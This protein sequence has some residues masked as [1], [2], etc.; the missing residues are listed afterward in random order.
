MPV[1]NE[2]L[3]NYVRETFS[4]EDE[5]LSTIRTEIPRRG[6][7]EITVRP[8][9]GRFLQ[10]IVAASGARMAVEIG[11]L[12]G[13]SGVWIAR[14]LPPGGKL[15]SLELSEEHAAVAADH[16]EMAG[17]AD[18]VDL[19]VGDAHDLLKDLANEGPFEFVFIDADKEGYPAYLDW[20]EAN[21]RPR[22]IVAGHNAF[23]FGTIDD[24]SDSDPGVAALRL[25]NER[26]A[27]DDHFI[28]TVFPAGDGTAVGVLRKNT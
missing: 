14:G 10:F 24:S 3:E 17:L 1:Y 18:K 13:Y 28:S 12:G 4:A 9:E 8:E 11:T 16:F 21:L 22:G 2:A 15:I 27:N 7:P 23:G 5:I 25:F 6:L 19:R 26:L 20:A